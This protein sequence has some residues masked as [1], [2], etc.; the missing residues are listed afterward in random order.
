MSQCCFAY[1]S[2]TFH[3]G[4]CLTELVS[5][6]SPFLR[7]HTGVPSQLRLHILNFHSLLLLLAQ[8]YSLQLA[9]LGRIF[10]TL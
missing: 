10:T 8:L 3:A 5:A 9:L 4:F 1:F 6:V 2:T 7:T